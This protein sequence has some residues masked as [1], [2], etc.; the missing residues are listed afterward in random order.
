MLLQND[1]EH[2]ARLAKFSGAR[3]ISSAQYFGREEE[4]TVS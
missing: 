1:P 3:S 2:Q 4:G